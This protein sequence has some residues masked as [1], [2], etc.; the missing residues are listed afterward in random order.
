MDFNQLSLFFIGVCAVLIIT[1]WACN[2]GSIQ[3]NF[4]VAHA[5]GKDKAKDVAKKTKTKIFGFGKD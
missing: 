5:I 4:S 3:E 2:E 1:T